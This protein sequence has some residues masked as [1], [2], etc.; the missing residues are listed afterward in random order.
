MFYHTRAANAGV[1][2]PLLVEYPVFHKVAAG[3]IRGRV[4]HPMKKSTGRPPLGQAKKSNVVMVR[5]SNPQF[6]I[7]HVKASRAGMGRSEFVR[8]G[9]LNAEVI[10]VLSDEEKSLLHELKNLARISTR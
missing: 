8:E 6:D 4:F 5:F 2:R 3:V 10:V 9:A 1:R 7:I